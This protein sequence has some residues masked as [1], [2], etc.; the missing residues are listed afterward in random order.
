MSPSTPKNLIIPFRRDRKQ[1]FASGTEAEL[2]KSKVR[3]A[4][5]TRTGEL[6]W[7]TNFGARLENLRHQSNDL[8]LSEL[9]RVQIRAI[10]RRWVPEIEVLE[11]SPHRVESRLELNLRFQRRDSE[12]EVLTL[13]LLG[14]RTP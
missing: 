12:V 11:V 1:D 5:L 6:P 4:I 9:A 10:L 7:R 3:Q 8:V 13:S 2:L 14:G